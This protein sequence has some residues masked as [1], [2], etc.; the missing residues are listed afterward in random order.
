MGYDMAI[1]AKSELENNLQSDVS[2]VYKSELIAL[3]KQEHS[4]VSREV[5]NGVKPDEYKAL[6]GLL[7]SI[8]EAIEV[9]ELM[10]TRLQKA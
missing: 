7:K 8:E 6:S 5:N 9:V 4:K 2:G 10:W 3:F 1:T